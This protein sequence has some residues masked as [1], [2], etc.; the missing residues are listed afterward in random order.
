[1]GTRSPE[2]SDL[3]EFPPLW[4]FRLAYT[5]LTRLWDLLLKFCS[6]VGRITSKVG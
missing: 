4:L 2:S 3:V 6:S 1:M 5:L